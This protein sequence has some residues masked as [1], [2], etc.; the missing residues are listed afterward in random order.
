MPATSD[1]VTLLQG[2]RRNSGFI[3]G[4]RNTKPSMARYSKF[5]SPLRS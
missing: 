3:N 2:L 1:Q 5:W 4:W